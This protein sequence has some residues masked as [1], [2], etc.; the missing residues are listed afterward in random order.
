MIQ[1]PLIGQQLSTFRV[2]RLIGRGGMAQVYY[3]LDIK[4]QRP[5]A[6]KV[7]DARYRDNPSYAERFVKEAR[8]VARWRQENIIQIYYADDQDGLYYYVMEFIDGKDL[9]SILAEYSAEGELM[10]VADILRIGRAI[11]RALDYAHKQGVIHR[12]VK[13][14]N[15][16][17]ASD[18]RVVLGDFGLALDVQQGS[19]GEVFGSPHYISPEQAR[20]SAD[21]SPLSD[22]YSLGVILFEMLTG[23]VPFD[24]PSPTSVALQ[25][26]TQPPPLPTSLNPEINAETEAVLLRA[27]SK[28][29]NQRYQSGAELLNALEK[30]LTMQEA[31]KKQPAVLPLPPMPASVAGAGPVAPPP[32]V[33]S[34][35]PVSQ[36]NTPQAA[37]TVIQRKKHSFPWPWLLA[38]LV[39]LLVL[40]VAGLGLVSA[41]LPGAAGTNLVSITP[42]DSPTAPASDTPAAAASPTVTSVVNEG[43]L[44]AA[45]ATASA[46]TQPTEAPSATETGTPTITPTLENTPDETAT[47][48]S[49][50]AEATSTLAEIPTETPTTQPTESLPPPSET[51]TE[52]AASPTA[53]IQLPTP[54]ASPTVLHP[55]GKLMKLFYDENG[56]YLLNKSDSSRSISALIFE[57]LSVNGLPE[58]RFEGWRWAE[59]YPTLHVNRCMRIEIQSP[60]YMNPIECENRYLSK[61]VIERD[62]GMV[63]WTT[64]QNSLQFRILWQKEEVARCDIGAVTCEFYIP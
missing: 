9:G 31:T 52:P 35:L 19:F 40:V 46:T 2:E 41:D 37:T 18:G 5:V 60:R 26:I 22:L 47:A 45:S 64:K 55:N 62:S 16:M 34:A 50:A 57:R 1:D 29:P 28:I 27:L 14:T 17:V 54:A 10:P 21:V 63:F 25:H 8:S 42:T 53:T 44:P 39:I 12:D 15:V 3:G 33:A 59:F 48:T 43:V 30:A 13:P 23:V 49:G 61:R 56:F 58:E 38:G 4:L 24:D 51:A 6:I 36:P 20:R 7:I 11:A 32:L